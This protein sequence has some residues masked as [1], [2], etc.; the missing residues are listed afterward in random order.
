[1][2]IPRA[3]KILTLLGVILVLGFASSSAPATTDNCN[4]TDNSKHTFTWIS[5][6]TPELASWAKNMSFTDVVVSDNSEAS[7]LNLAREGITYWH[8]VS[9]Y[10]FEYGDLAS[11]ETARQ[12][13]L[14]LVGQSPNHRVYLDDTH[15]IPTKEWGIGGFNNLL[16]AVRWIQDNNIGV[17]ILDGYASYMNYKE[18]ESKYVE[19][20]YLNMTGINFDIYQVPT[21]SYSSIILQLQEFNP[22]TIGVYLWAY[23]CADKG[24]S[25]DTMTDYYLGSIYEQA[26]K[27][28]MTRLVVWNGY[29]GMPEILASYDFPCMYAACLYYHPEWW[30]KVKAEN[31][32]FLGSNP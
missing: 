15:C 12:N 6:V 10:N 22:E 17:F 1:M 31:M 28:N 23:L 20:A 5:N 24:L 16:S 4:T 21:I 13:L 19:P 8:V 27:N 14:E 11:I 29:S 2:H 18:K 9:S 25:W 30:E 32:K 26:R 3:I 7:Y